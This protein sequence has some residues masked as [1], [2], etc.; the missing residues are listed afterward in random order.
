[1]KNIKS[2]KLFENKMWYK[3]IPQILDWLKEK[4][5]KTWVL[6]DTETTGLGGPKKE[7]VFFIDLFYT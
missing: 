3:S 4:S 1:M 2:F 7:P 6:L 5:N